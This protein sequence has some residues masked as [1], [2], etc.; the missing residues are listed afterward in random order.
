MSTL[1]TEMETYFLKLDFYIIDLFCYHKYFDPLTWNE[2]K[3]YAINKYVNTL[4]E[5]Y[6]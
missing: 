1:P 4:Y 3:S 2:K 5:Y 6:I